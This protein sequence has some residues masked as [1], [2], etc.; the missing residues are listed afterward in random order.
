MPK[1]KDNLPTLDQ[2]GN[3]IDCWLQEELDL[4]AD[5]RR[6]TKLSEKILRLVIEQRTDAIAKGQPKQEVQRLE[7]QFEHDAV[8]KARKRVRTWLLGAQGALQGLARK[9]EELE[10]L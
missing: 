4:V 10:D 1:T 5:P 9:L 2:I 6:V 3:M 7:A 8:V